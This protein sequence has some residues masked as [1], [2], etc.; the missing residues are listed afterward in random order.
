MELIIEEISRNKKIKARHKFATK[1]ISIGRGFDN[2]IILSDPH[3][4]PEH[5]AIK[6]QDNQWYVQDLQTLNGTMLSDRQHIADWHPIKSGDIILLGKTQ[7]RL[8]LPNH[9]VAQSIAFTKVEQFVE[10][11]GR[12]TFLIAMVALFC[13]ISFALTYLQVSQV[14]VPYSQIVMSVVYSTIAYAMWPLLCSLMAFLNKN[15]S[16]VGSQMGVSFLMLNLFWLV[17]FIDATMA[18][19]LSSQ[20]NWQWL[21]TVLY[22]ALTFSLFWFNLYIAFSQSKWRRV[23]ISALLTVIIF[24]GLYLQDR[25]DSVDFNP[26]P[27]FDS[28]IMI[29]ALS[30]SPASSVDEYIEDSNRLFEE[31]DKASKKKANGEDGE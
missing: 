3:I 6:W 13:A 20:I 17:D 16:R 31:V 26:H 30:V 29:P 7:L 28:T 5:L 23:T 19:N 4:C 11:C 14:E 25:G 21:T 8:F 2:D 9:P 18:F 15:E 1:E 10:N 12:W 24:G 27:V 22:V